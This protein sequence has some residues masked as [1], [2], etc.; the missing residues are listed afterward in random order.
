M[1]HRPRR[2]AHG[3][4]D[5]LD[6]AQ[7]AADR[8]GK[9][10]PPRLEACIG[11]VLQP[12]LDVDAGAKIFDLDRLDLVRS[13]NDALGQRE[14][15]CEIIEIGR[16]RH[17]HRMRRAGEGE[18]HRRLLRHHAVRGRRPAGAVRQPRYLRRC[19]AARGQDYSAASSGAIRRLWRA[20]SL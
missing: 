7:P 5:R 15:E 6:A 10:A 4:F 17:H 12:D 20:C 9:P 3:L 13:G 2:R 19:F 11:L 16:A 18:R 14:A 8:A 1:T